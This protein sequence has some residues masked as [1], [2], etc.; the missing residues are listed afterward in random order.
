MNEKIYDIDFSRAVRWNLRRKKRKPRILALLMA[1]AMP[2][3]LIYQDFLRFRKAKLYDLMITPQVC[4]LEAFL[5]DR[6][7]LI[8]RRIYIDDAISYPPLYLYQDEE[9][10][11]V[12]LYTDFENKPVYLYTDGE[13][14]EYAD[15]FVVFVPHD[16][17]FSL[18]EMTSLIMRKRLPGM[19]FKIQKF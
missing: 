3:Q 16:I 12:D 1:M 5:N 13:G 10:K 14:G 11:P 2:F 6:Y 7:D 4:Y 8:Q 9:L 19:R 17:D 15:D 18:I